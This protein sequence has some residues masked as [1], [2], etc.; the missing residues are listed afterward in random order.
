[1]DLVLSI[2][3]LDYARE[4]HVRPGIDTLPASRRALHSISCLL[5]NMPVIVNPPVGQATA[6]SFCED[7]SICIAGLRN[8][9]RPTPL[10][11]TP[12]FSGQTLITPPSAAHPNWAP[13]PP[14]PPPRAQLTTNSLHFR[15]PHP[16]L[17]PPP[18][19]YPSL[20]SSCHSSSAHPCKPSSW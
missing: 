12:R 20:A 1:M 17:H 16:F 13:L 15:S 11:A 7:L 4:A 8:E 3:Y 9:V 6:V 14:P 18:L 19:P 2:E 5:S 10:R